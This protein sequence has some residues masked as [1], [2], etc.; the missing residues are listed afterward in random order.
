MFS[1]EKLAKSAKG[2][3]GKQWA[4][5]LTRPIAATCYGGQDSHG[6]AASWE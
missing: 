5:S 1:I 3:F 2:A 6:T 4:Y